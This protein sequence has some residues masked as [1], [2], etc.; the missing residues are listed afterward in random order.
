MTIWNGPSGNASPSAG[1]LE[2]R[3]V[4]RD[5]VVLLV[6]VG[7]PRLRDVEPGLEEHVAAA[8]VRLVEPHHDVTAAVLGQLHG[9]DD[10]GPR[11]HPHD[12]LDGAAGDDARRQRERVALLDGGADV[13]AR[14]RARSGSV[15]RPRSVSGSGKRGLRASVRRTVV[16]PGPRRSPDVDR[17]TSWP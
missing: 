6:Q 3:E 16:G 10:R 5:V 17:L 4:G 9:L 11:D 7:H 15:C 8:A 1:D 14:R 2:R 12:G 13:C